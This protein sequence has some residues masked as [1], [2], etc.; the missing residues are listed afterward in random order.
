MIADRR[1][2]RCCVG[3]ATPTGPSRATS[4]PRNRTKRLEYTGRWADTRPVTGG[5]DHFVRPDPNAL[6]RQAGASARRRAAAEA[7]AVPPVRRVVDR[8]LDRRTDERVW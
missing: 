5:W 2:T 4:S 8:I 6:Q 1:A 3:Q 7:A